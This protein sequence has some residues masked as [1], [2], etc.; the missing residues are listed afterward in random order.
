MALSKLDDAC[1]YLADYYFF[2]N[3]DRDKAGIYVKL[4]LSITPGD[5]RFEVLE[6]SILGTYPEK[7][8]EVNRQFEKLLSK[9]PNDEKIMLHYAKFLEKHNEEKSIQLY[10]KAVRLYPDNKDVL[11][12]LGSYFTNQSSR[13][14]NEGGDLGT[15]V[16]FMN[17]AVTYFE[18][19]HKMNRNDREIIEILIQLYGNLNMEKEKNAMKVKLKNMI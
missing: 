10:E 13:I 2:R 15:V 3:A 9:N 1:Y 18:M 16:K 8:N 6:I 14:F 11:F 17:K 7:T 4:G 12:A 19:L 5:K